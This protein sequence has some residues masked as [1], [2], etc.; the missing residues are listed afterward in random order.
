MKFYQ[1]FEFND[2]LFYGIDLDTSCID[3]QICTNRTPKYCFHEFVSHNKLAA[4]NAI[5]PYADCTI[6]IARVHSHAKNAPIEDRYAIR[7]TVWRN[8]LAC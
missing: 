3:K 5:P 8:V 7:Y 2:H 4:L 1:K 6:S